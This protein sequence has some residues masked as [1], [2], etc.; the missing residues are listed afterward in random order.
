MIFDLFFIFLNIIKLNKKQYLSTLEYQISV[1][2]NEKSC[3][4]RSYFS[5]TNAKSLFNQTAYRYQCQNLNKC[6]RLQ[7]WPSINKNTKTYQISVSDCNVSNDDLLDWY[8]S[9]SCILVSYTQISVHIW[10]LKMSINKEFKNIFVAK[11]E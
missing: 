10:I 2:W 4:K 1:A 8:I 7:N 6:V 5:N 3:P 9:L 11:N